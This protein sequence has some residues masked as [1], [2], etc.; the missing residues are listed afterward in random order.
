MDTSQNTCK[1]L[2]YKDKILH[3][4]DCF[5]ICFKNKSRCNRCQTAQIRLHSK[6]IKFEENVTNQTVVKNYSLLN[7]QLE[8]PQMLNAYQSEARMFQQQNQYKEEWKNKLVKLLHKAIKKATDKEFLFTFIETQF[9]NYSLQ[10]AQVFRFSP[11]EK[12]FWLLVKHAGGPK[13]LRI[14]RGLGNFGKSRKE[15]INNGFNLFLPSNSFLKEREKEG[16]YGLDPD[17][18]HIKEM[19]K[20]HSRENGFPFF[21]ISYDGI[22]LLENYSYDHHLNCIIGGEKT[23]T[24]EEFITLPVNDLVCNSGN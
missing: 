14:L 23:Y 19:A 16:Y 5:Q 11:Q 4:D 3:A 8:T 6:A 18:I 12:A 1:K 9:Y 24:V 22:R 10:S 13:V 21:I 17:F 2:P 15:H 20:K 7:H